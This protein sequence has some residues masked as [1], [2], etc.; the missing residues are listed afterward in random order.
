[1]QYDTAETTADRLH[2][3]NWSKRSRF[4]DCETL[5]ERRKG[6]VLVTSEGAHWPKV[7]AEPWPAANGPKAAFSCQ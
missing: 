1:M 5:G 3:G 4:L 2:D 6:V 7:S